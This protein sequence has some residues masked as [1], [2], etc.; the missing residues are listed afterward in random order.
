MRWILVL[1][2]SAF[3]ASANTFF[4]SGSGSWGWEFPSD[5]GYNITLSGGPL[6]LS[7]SVSSLC[8]CLGEGTTSLGGSV[9]P[10]FGGSTGMGVAQIGGISS[11]NFTFSIGNGSGFLNLYDSN[12]APLASANLIGYVVLTTTF[13]EYEGQELFGASGTIAIVPTPE[14][15]TEFILLAGLAL[16]LIRKAPN[17]WPPSFRKRVAVCRPCTREDALVH[18]PTSTWLGS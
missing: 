6:F 3:G 11:P 18:S 1:L 5:G 17:L 16:I 14:P 12:F 13:Q 10:L 9:L 7:A 4:V 8:D 2:L 15:R